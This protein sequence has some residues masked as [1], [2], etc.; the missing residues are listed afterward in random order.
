MGL[1]VD[2]SKV[3]A[4]G[5]RADRREAHSYAGSPGNSPRCY[6]QDRVQIQ[7]FR[8]PGT[9]IRRARTH[10]RTAGA[11]DGWRTRIRGGY[12]RGGETMSVFA[13]CGHRAE[14]ICKEC[15]AC[16]ICCHC[17]EIGLVHINT[18]EAAEALA[19]WARKK[20]EEL[21]HLGKVDA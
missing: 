5:E 19:R 9:S 21:D 13:S 3:L 7:V 15:G 6:Q 8:L 10:R 12:A 14:W 11:V 17:G 2:K 20:R 18:R 4:T 1:S 16:A